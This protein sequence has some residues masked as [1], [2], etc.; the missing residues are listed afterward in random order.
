MASGLS[1]RTWLRRSGDTL[2]PRPGVRI[3]ES[4]SKTA[5]G[6]LRAFCKRPMAASRALSRASSAFTAGCSFTTSFDCS[7]LRLELGVL[8]LLVLELLVLE[9]VEHEQARD[10]GQEEHHHHGQ[11]ELA[12]LAEP[13]HLA[14]SAAGG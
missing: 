7:N 6:P 10:L 1:R 13:R 8:A 2:G 11:P 5:V 3:R 9:P 4:S 12:A 14:A